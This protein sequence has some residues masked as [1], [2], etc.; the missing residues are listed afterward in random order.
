MVVLL[1][2]LFFFKM[3]DFDVKPKLISD[4]EED[5]GVG[6][7]IWALAQMPELGVVE[8]TAM[9]LGVGYWCSLSLRKSEEKREF[10]CFGFWERENWVSFWREKERKW[11]YK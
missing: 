7:D 1:L 3:M 8:G 4:E 5:E 9:A 6:W 10:L 2:G 11:E